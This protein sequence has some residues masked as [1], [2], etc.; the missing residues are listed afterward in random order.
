MLKPEKV[1]QIST[2]TQKRHQEPTLYWY[3]RISYWYRR[4]SCVTLVIYEINT[5]LTVD[6]ATV[7][8]N[9]W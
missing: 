6:R 9:K 5:V 4:I 3:R 2:E 7:L 8:L 1:I